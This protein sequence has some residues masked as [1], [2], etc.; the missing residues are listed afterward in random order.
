MTDGSEPGLTILHLNFPA[1]WDKILSYDEV[2]ML[3]NHPI[4]KYSVRAFKTVLNRFSAAHTCSMTGINRPIMPQADQNSMY[5]S[6]NRAIY[7]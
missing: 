7:G 1:Y 5:L 6:T 4:M 2:D 3:A